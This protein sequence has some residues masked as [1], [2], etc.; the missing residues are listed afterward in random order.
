MWI[1]WP[2]IYLSL[3][4]VINKPH[5]FSSLSLSLSLS[6]YFLC[7]DFSQG[8]VSWVLGGIQWDNKASVLWV[9]AVPPCSECSIHSMTEWHFYPASPVFSWADLNVS[10][11]DFNTIRIKL[12]RLL[13][14]V[15]KLKCSPKKCTTKQKKIIPQRLTL[16]T[17]I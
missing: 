9:D 3:E 4:R 5:F 14:S 17:R 11:G 15:K 10:R 8:R 7:T 6:P 12:F 16:F 13:F 2:L 1:T